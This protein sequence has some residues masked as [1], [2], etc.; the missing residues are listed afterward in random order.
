MNQDLF[1]Y[2]KKPYVY[3]CYRTGDN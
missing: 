2:A 1:Y 3:D